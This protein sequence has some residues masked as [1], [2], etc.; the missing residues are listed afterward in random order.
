MGSTPIGFDR[1][2]RA[3]TVKRRTHSLFRQ[4]LYWYECIP[5]MRLD[6]LRPLMEA[7]DAIVAQHAV[8]RAAFGVI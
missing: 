5:T 6:W 7:F 2:L 4:G 3:N 1:K 8:F